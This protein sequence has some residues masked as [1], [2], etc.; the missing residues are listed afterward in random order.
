MEA[1]ITED[2]NLLIIP[3]NSAER[4]ALKPFWNNGLR[5]ASSAHKDGIAIFVLIS[6]LEDNQKIVIKKRKVNK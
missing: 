4:F 5:L 3:N 6:P 1:S 2:G